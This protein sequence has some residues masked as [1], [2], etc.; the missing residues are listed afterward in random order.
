[1]EQGKNG[2][3][4]RYRP[5]VG[6]MILNKEGEI[7]IGERLS[8]PGSW[9]M[10]QG[11]IEK[12]EDITLAAKREM[13]EEIGTDK[14]DLLAIAPETISYDFPENLYKKLWNGRYHGQEQ[15]WI[16]FRFTGKDSDIDLNYDVVPE[17]SDWKWITP[18]EFFDVCVSFKKNTYEKVFKF[19]EIYL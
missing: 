2:S 19:F 4:K 18:A 3:P 9:Q 12:D 1:M 11:G 13:K 6:L 10:P 16:A 5:S 17:F 15:T 8:H 14:A 7:L